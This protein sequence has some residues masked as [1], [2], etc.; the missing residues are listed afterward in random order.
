MKWDPKVMGSFS[1][2][3][4]QPWG[5]SAGACFRVGVEPDGMCSFQAWG[6]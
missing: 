1:D 5:K 4:S 3:P 6:L 2:E